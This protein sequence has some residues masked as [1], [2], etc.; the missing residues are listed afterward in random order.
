M[1]S[2]MKTWSS[3]LTSCCAVRVLTCHCTQIFQKTALDVLLHV[4][5]LRQVL[6]VLSLGSSTH[7]SEMC[8]PISWVYHRAFEVD[9]L[10]SSETLKVP[11]KQEIL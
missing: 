11:R 8:K 2:S 6:I 5:W 9:F 1:S 10:R 7:R 4:A 3:Y